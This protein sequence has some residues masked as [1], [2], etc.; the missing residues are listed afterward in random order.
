MRALVAAAL[1]L[2]STAT[3]AVPTVEVPQH[4]IEVQLTPASGELRVVD[5]V[6]VSGRKWIDFRLAPWLD[7]KQLLVDGQVVLVARSGNSFR[8]ALRDEGQ[9]VLNFE[10]LGTVPPRDMPA[11][12]PAGTYSSSG[13]DGAYLPGYAAWIPLDPGERLRYR[14]TVSVPAGQRA[15]ATGKLVAEQANSERYQATFSVEQPAE[16]PSLFAGPYVIGE[17][18]VHGLRLRTY[19]HTELTDLSDAYLASAA[20]YIDRFAAI[21]GDYPYAD[22]HIVSAP[23]PVGLGF[24]NLTYVGRRVLPLPFMRARSLAHE[25]LHNWW[26]NGVAVDYASGNWAEGLTTYMADYALAEDRGSEAARAMRV[27]WLRDYAAL[28]PERDHAVLAFR[29]K[30]HRAAQVIGYNKIAFVFHMLVAEIGQTAFDDGIRRFWTIN[31]FRKAG[32]RQLQAA[33]EQSSERDLRWFFEQWLTRKGAPRIA[34]GAH[35]VK[36]IDG[37]FKISVELRQSEPQYRLRLPVMLTTRTGVERHSV[38]IADAI[39]ELE[40]IA[41][42]LPLSIHIDPNSDVFRR[43]QASEAPPIM[44]DVTLHPAAITLVATQD[45]AYR[46]TGRELA[47]RL[48]DTVPRFDTLAEAK[49]ATV[50]LLLVADSDTAK[51]LFTQLQVD[52]FPELPAATHTAAVWTLRR[53]NGMP[54]LVVTAP[55][56]P[57]LQALLR[58]LPHYGGQSYVLFDDSSAVRK[59]VWPVARGPLFQTL[60]NTP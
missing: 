29:S 20:K 53:R 8:V 11:E 50:P 7:V 37:T 46:E 34:L 31:A 42:A 44:R 30:A 25:V 9:H 40:F 4:S 2:A 60:G 1:Y 32:W 48:M 38:T 58:P 56:V 51:E 18:R 3:F 22:F 36:S 41:T 5:E 49:R 33:F 43:L 19:F 6:R 16:P 27:K 47:A 21:I 28:P 24:P 39:T 52:K 13:G 54:M 14:L 15:V 45:P 35:T 10:L 12:V 23:L 17:R 59:G 26:G 55:D 57:S